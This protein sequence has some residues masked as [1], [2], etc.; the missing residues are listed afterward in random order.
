MKILITDSIDQEGVDILSAEEG[1]DVVVDQSL[2]G[3]KLAENIGPYHALITRSGT[4][5]T[6]GILEKARE[7]KVIGRAGVFGGGTSRWPRS[8]RRAVRS[9]RRSGCPL[10][11]S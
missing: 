6:V 8:A 7:L 9:C 1:F 2:K 11:T 4:D 5:V 10:P 3:D